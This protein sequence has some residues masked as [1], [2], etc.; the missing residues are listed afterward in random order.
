MGEFQLKSQYR[1]WIFFDQ[2]NKKESQPFSLIQSQIF[3]LGLKRKDF[4]HHLIWTPGWK[5]W[6]S[7]EEFL[8]SDQKVFT[9]LK[10][11]I[12]AQKTKKSKVVD[13][14]P[15]E[16]PNIMEEEDF[17]DHTITSELTAPTIVRDDT[18]VIAKPE[19]QSSSSQFTQIST[20]K[21]AVDK[22]NP[23]GQNKGGS[24]YWNPDFSAQDLQKNSKDKITPLLQL[25]SERREG[26]R[27]DLMLEVLIISSKGKTFRSHSKNISLTGIKLIDALPSEF[28]KHFFDM[29]IINRFEE[30]P[31]KSRLLLRCKIVGDLSDPKRL[32]FVSPSDESIKRLSEFIEIYQQH[33]S[34][35]SK[36]S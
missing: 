30:N 22:K 20:E 7:L 12:P 29:I 23:R 36:S 24:G 16:I 6:M 26:E 1:V 3:I 11:P 8:E 21:P 32:T 35:I 27:F 9:K 25:D 13:S 5:S 33:T 19:G 2:R 4:E 17:S 31:Q 28:N 34:A 14:V 15:T 10:V 18:L